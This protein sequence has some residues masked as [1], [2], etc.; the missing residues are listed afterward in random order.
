M[1]HAHASTPR[2]RADWISRLLAHAGDYGVVSALS[3]AVRVLAQELPPTARLLA[4]DEIYGKDRHGAY[5][6]VVDAHAGAVW[7]AVGPVA[8]D[9]ET[10]TLL[11]WEAQ[12]RGLRWV[13]TVSDGG[14][15]MAGA[16]ATVAPHTP[17][18]RDVWHVLH[19]CSKVH[20]RLARRVAA[21]RDQ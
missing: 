10:W 18:Q 3:R 16:C 4:L 9:T 11:L 17:H 21:L 8:V 15:A 1:G 7:L 5:L 19:E 2:E 6:S 12:E 20:G 13:G 14:A